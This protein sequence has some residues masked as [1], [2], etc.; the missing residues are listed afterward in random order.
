[1]HIVS[2]S[3][4][5]LS[6]LPY[7]LLQACTETL[8]LSS[9]SHS[10]SEGADGDVEMMDSSSN[11]PLNIVVAEGGI[12]RE[13][14]EF[15]PDF[16]RNIIPK[17]DWGALVKASASLGVKTLPLEKPDD[18][19]ENESLLEALHAV[20]LDIH[21][22]EG[23]LVCNHCGRSYPINNGIPNMLLREDEM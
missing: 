7:I 14:T 6:H 21:V 2:P 23:E 4:L 1:M 16:V 11:F 15:N 20:L 19:L 10:K 3:L 13:E 17:L 18:L 8:G 12:L 5:S 9:T 22:N